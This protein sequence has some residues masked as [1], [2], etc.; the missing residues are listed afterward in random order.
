MRAR[1]T[2]TWTWA[3]RSSRLSPSAFCRLLLLLA[4]V[5]FVGACQR[6]SRQPSTGDIRIELDTPLFS[7]AV[8]PTHLRVRLLDRAG[9]PVDNAVVHARGDMT[10]AGMVPVFTEATGAQ[11]GRYML[12]VEWTMSGDWIVTVD[13]ELPDGRSAS[14]QFE[15]TV[16]GD[17]IYCTVDN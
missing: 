3:A 7:P 1:S 17:D 16:T 14:R 6:Q 13:A 15:L 4:A 5:M 2:A 11:D 10:H 9:N 8:G 12:P